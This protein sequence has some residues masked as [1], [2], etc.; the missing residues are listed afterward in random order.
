MNNLVGATIDH[1]Q[2]LVN[3][4]ETPTRI[5]YRAYNT[6]SQNQTALEVLKTSGS[7]PEDLLGLINEQIRKNAVLTHP[8]IATIVDTGLHEG[9]IYIVYSFSPTHP[10]RRFFNRTYSWQESSRELVAVTHAMAYAHEKGVVHG[11]L[12]PA[13]IVL[14]ERRNPILFDFGFEQIITNYLLADAPGAWLNRWGFEYRPP[15]QLTGALP[16]ARSDIYAMGMMIHEWLNGK[17]PLLDSTVLGTLQMRKNDSV[18][19]EKKSPVPPVIQNLIRKCLALD[20][21]G[22]YQSMQEVYI[23][24]ARGALDMSI[25]RRMVRKPLE[26]PRQRFSTRLLVRRLRLP[27]LFFSIAAMVIILMNSM[28][29]PLTQLLAPTATSTPTATRIQPTPTRTARPTS[30]P[31][32]LL[33]VTETP[34]PAALVFPVFQETPFASAVEQT[35]AVNNINNM[36]MLSILGIGDVD[37]LVSSP[38]GK[39]VVAASSIGI[40]VFDAQSLALINHI[41]TR[42]WITALDFSRDSKILA[43]GDRDGLVQLWDT[44]TWQEATA[45][46]SGHNKVVLD[47]AFSPDGTKLASVSLDGN[48]IQWKVNA[49]DG[50]KATRQPVNRVT[51][52]AYSGDSTRIVTGGDDL[53]L[54]IWDAASLTFMQKKDY[55]AQIVDIASI[56][57]SNAF[58]IGGND[59]SVAILDISG[60]VSLEPVG[61]LRYPLTSV[62]ASSDGKLVSAGDLNG[63]IAVWE[64]AGDNVTELAR[65]RS[66]VVGNAADLEAP[67]SPH[68][69]A[70][71]Q[72][73]QLVFSGLHSGTIRSLNA[74]TGADDKQ[75]LS[76]NAHV[77]KF[78]ISHDS[79][80]LI[81]QQDNGVLTIWDLWGGAPRYQVPGQIKAGDPFSHDDRMFAA[82]SGG[83]GA[84]TVTVFNTADGK[85][86]YT[87][88]SQQDL[89]S[90]QFINTST[91]L[92]TVYD[93]F[94]NLWAM[95]NG[96]QLET[97]PVFDGTGC[98]A[99]RDIYD[100]DVAS[101][102]NYFHVVAND[103][104]K[105]GICQFEPLNWTTAFNESK[106][107]A[108]YGGSSKLTLVD[109]RRSGSEDQN[110]RGVNRKNIVTVA[111][112]P[113][114]D[115]IAAAY[116]D[117]TIHIW[118]VETREEIFSLYGHN[119]AIT[120]LQFTAD[121]KLLL[122]T[123]AD[124]TIRLW[125][126]PYQ[127]QR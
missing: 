49:T 114:A 99:I 58:V 53:L 4:R 32:P 46:F 65:P 93:D 89:K 50:Q 43:T 121:G 20:P 103:Q 27:A 90:I 25:T 78:A 117:D 21:N 63:G 60:E 11:A 31:A 42:S 102:T 96:Q 14:D 108:V 61:R 73:G 12:H 71:S 67:G 91:Q 15:E 2:I 126:I 17:L 45:P 118:D 111:I 69:V 105:P 95:S 87:L 84:A 120:G 48:L 72:D 75:A 54:S 34:Q 110:L 30:T 74:S 33:P 98:Q 59:Q 86:L 97:R 3:V 107:I 109:I 9:L 79:Q 85:I 16:D 88:K 6:R 101:I 57:G 29:M 92:I 77:E 124:G 123:S 36:V 127:A 51:S 44:S 23:V 113:N 76:L 66:F 116:D 13:S 7:Q 94:T 37:R 40:F 22:R 115:L 19:A 104:N 47:L 10:M 38:D 81:T 35:I 83:P 106:G 70:F 62:A 119:D 82:A 56:E 8:S 18:P 28:G 52:V 39:H 80:V 41:D 68:S 1:Y 112:S 125:G 122:S 64:L 24:L 55:P 100:Q 26:I 5:L